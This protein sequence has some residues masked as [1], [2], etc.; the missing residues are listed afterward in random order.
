MPFVQVDPSKLN[1]D[2]PQLSKSTN[3]F[4]PVDPSQIEFD[5]PDGSMVGSIFNKRANEL[6]DNVVAYQNN[7]KSLP[8]LGLNFI[9]KAG[10]GTANDLIG[11][12]INAA[13]PDPAKQALAAGAQ[14]TANAI[15]STKT[16]KYLSDKLLAVHDIYN[17][18]MGDNPRT[19]SALESV[20]N[21]AALVPAKK[22]IEPIQEIA[23]D[24]SNGIKGL[25]DIYAAKYPTGN[26]PFDPLQ[27]KIAQPITRDMV[28][29]VGSKAYKAVEDSG[30]VFAAPVTD[31]AMAVI[32]NAKQ[33]PLFGG[34]VFTKEQADINA[35][36]EDYLPARG[37]AM[38]MADLQGLDST[39]GDKAAQAYVA[40][41]YN[42]GRIVSDVQDKIRELVKPENISKNEIIGNPE[43]AN[44]L[45]NE[46]V[47][48]W[49]T[50]AK[51]G[52]IEKI[53]NRAN[54]MDNPST[55]IKTGFRNLML[56]DGKMAQYPKEVQ[57]L[58][59]KAAKTGKADDLLGILGSRLN[60]IAGLAAHG[61]AGA[62]VSN[63]ASAG[64]RGARS[65][66]KNNQANAVLD[67]L[68]DQIRPIIEKYNAPKITQEAGGPMKLLPA[69]NTVVNVDSSGRAIPPMSPADRAVLG[70]MAS[71]PRQLTLKE[72]YAMP[73]DQ[74]KIELQY[75]LKNRNHRR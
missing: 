14:N 70:S 35:A 30:T 40:G 64:F 72:I 22:V 41:N 66:L 73:P 39:L 65:A 34:K 47:P 58:I 11:A 45:L 12:G 28:R 69:P 21:I 24:T 60:A 68:V 75:Y 48:L 55:G 20:G 19:A 18:F 27:M 1:F 33:K 44:I 38:T 51:M 50:Q 36:L 29:D 74:A 54:A 6:A 3:G 31:R 15:D 62:V 59:T 32:E 5:K 10:A 13:I 37:Q 42:K 46:A 43:G 61:P 4:V 25:S 26:A 2:A 63:V 49:S 23:S 9:G 52:D 7:E 16:G 57:K 53:V 56:N 17:Q 71:S 67:A 8:E